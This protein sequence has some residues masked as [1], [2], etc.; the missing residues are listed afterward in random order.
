MRIY[1]LTDRDFED[2]YALMEKI[3]T[4]NKLKHG[5]GP[6]VG[7]HFLLDSL[8]R[9]YRYHFIGWRNRMMSGDTYFRGPDPPRDDT[10]SAI[11]AEIERL[12]ALL[13]KEPKA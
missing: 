2:F 1:Q 3:E 7:S 9:T 13:P 8:R 12:Q 10:A 11:R 6:A 5:D 4:E